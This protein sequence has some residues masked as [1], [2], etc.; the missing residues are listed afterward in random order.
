MLTLKRVPWRVVGPPDHVQAVVTA[1]MLTGVWRTCEK[2][3]IVGDG[4]IQ[5]VSMNADHWSR[6]DSIATFIV[7]YANRDMVSR[8]NRGEV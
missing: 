1:L 3:V 4:F 2:D 6:W 7:D 8:I 5:I